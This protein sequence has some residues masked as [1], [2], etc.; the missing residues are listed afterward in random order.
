MLKRTTGFFSNKIKLVQNFFR[1]AKMGVNKTLRRIQQSLVEYIKTSPRR[2]FITPLKNLYLAVSK[3]VNDIKMG[4][5]R[6][7]FKSVVGFV[8]GFD[9]FN[10]DMKNLALKIVE[11]EWDTVVGVMIWFVITVI[12]TSAITLKTVPVQMFLPEFVKSFFFMFF[13]GG[14]L[15][16]TFCIFIM[17]IAFVMTRSRRL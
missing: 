9:D 8:K 17:S 5:E 14:L 15:V 11:Q 4:L 12:V 1:S 13:L 6:R 3:K 16:L 7:V 10:S 2:F